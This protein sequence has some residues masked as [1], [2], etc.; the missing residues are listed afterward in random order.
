MAQI[1]DLVGRLN[2]LI[3]GI[4]FAMLTTVRT[5]GSLHSCPMA[6]RPADPSAV[7]W[8]ISDNNTEKAEAVRTSPRV[9]V[10]FTDPASQRYISVS[11]YCEMVRDNGRAKAMWDPQ[12]KAWFPA[13]LDDPNLILLKVNIHEA[14]YWDHSQNRMVTLL[15]FSRPAIE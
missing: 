7:L 11:G 13:G 9:N 2:E 5:D 15:G 8:F 1:A 3:R 4:P 14:E 6:T 10:A 12:Y